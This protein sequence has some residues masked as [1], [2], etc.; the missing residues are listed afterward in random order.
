M[1][2]TPNFRDNL[3]RLAWLLKRLPRLVRGRDVL[4][5]P[6]VQVP[7]QKVGHGY[8]T[9]S[10]ATELLRA[11]DLAYCFGLGEEISLEFELATKLG[12]EVHGFDPTP[13]SLEW[14]RRQDAARHFRVHDFG[15]AAKNGEVEFQLPDSPSHVSMSAARTSSKSGVI[16]ARVCSLESIH[17]RLG[18]GRRIALL[19]MDIEGSEYEVLSALAASEIRPSQIAVEFHHR[20]PEIGP[21]ATRDAVTQLARLGYLIA[22]I[23]PNGEEVLFIHSDALA[24]HT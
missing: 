11:G 21:E 23:S 20:F 14:V 15:L 8:G 4:L 17:D 10:L 7:L 24:H 16:R 12:I 13:R 18:D 1:R 19:K 2:R 22:D 9:W 6:Q 5:L 3:E